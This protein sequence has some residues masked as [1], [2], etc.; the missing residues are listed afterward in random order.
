MNKT[1]RIALL[2]A[3]ILISAGCASPKN[4]KLMPDIGSSNI[5]FAPAIDASYH[6]VQ[7]DLA[8]HV[9]V[10]VRWGGQV[11]NTEELEKGVRV[12]LFAFPLDAKGQPLTKPDQDFKGGRFAVDLDDTQATDRLFAGRFITVY[13]TVNGG[14]TLNNGPLET[15]IPLVVTQ[16]VKGWK[17]AKVR[18]VNPYRNTYAYRSP[19]FRYGHG[20]FGFRSGFRHGFGSRFRRFGH[21]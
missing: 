3:L 21:Y 9:G 16:E 11:I 6:Q 7:N 2:L 19:R 1:T 18:Q 17:L 10:N 13:G 14:L 8:K 12:T 4:V 20:V 15:I 5:R